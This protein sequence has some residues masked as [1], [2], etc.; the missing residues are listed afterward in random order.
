MRTCLV[1][2]LVGCGGAASA[3]SPA[4]PSP[5]SYRT[6]T[7]ALPGA[8]SDGV[9]MDYLL[10]DA[11]TS[12]LWAPAGNTGA[13]D[14]LTGDT[15]HP[16]EG[17]ATTEVE[18]RGR[19]IRVG[20]S[21]AALGPPGIVY[22]GSRGD[23]SVC[24]VDEVRL[25]RGACA[26]LD[27]MP[28]G[29]VYAAARNEVWVTT[30]RD[31]SLRVLDGTTLAETSRIALDGQPEGFAVDATRGRFYTNLEDKDRTLAIDL[32]SHATLATWEPRC[33]ED[34]PHGIRLIEREGFLLVACDDRVEVL[35][36]GHAGA[37]LGSLAT[38]AG[39]DDIDYAPGSRQV[40]AAAAEAG[41][42]TIASL[43]AT[44]ALTAIAVVPTGPGAR[45]AVVAPS[46][47]IYVAQ[48]RPGAIIV[49]EPHR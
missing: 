22:V 21:A 20:P 16:I 48:S 31:H 43:S 8:G 6:H 37:S 47:A 30:P 23:N 11:R 24:A 15:V 1:V 34:G 41:N 5:P 44:G 36:V 38:G 13:V 49:V 46:G 12:A 27:A 17:F 29:V 45:N 28:D 3:P 9:L 25:A 33:G 39:V 10:Y 18:R 4:P 40:V 32:A 42:L 26:H 35:D 7:I 2:F 19:R 14:V